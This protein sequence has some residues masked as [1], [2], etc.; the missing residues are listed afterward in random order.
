MRVRTTRLVPMF[1]LSRDWS[2][3]SA[4][5]GQHPVGAVADNVK[6]AQKVHQKGFDAFTMLICWSM[7]KQ[8]NSR[9]LGRSAVDNE[10][11]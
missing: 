5:G 11:A 8:R 7:W 1:L 4:L 3:S 9:A 2:G 6:R 10:E